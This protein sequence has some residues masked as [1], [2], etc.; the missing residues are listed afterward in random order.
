MIHSI[1]ADMEE[2]WK[3]IPGY[4][5]WYKVSNFGRVRSLDRYVNGKSSTK[6]IRKGRILK[7]CVHSCGYLYLT[8]SIEKKRKYLFIHRLV[9]EAFN[10]PIPEGM[11]VN[12]IN[13][14]K[15][16]NRLENLNLMTPKENINWGTHNKRVSE[17]HL[18]PVLQFTLDGELVRE[19]DSMEEAHKNGFEKANICNC[20]RGKLKQYKGFIWRYK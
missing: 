16:D 14:N 5:G 17:K 4:E 20:C 12:H 7:P 1:F 13:E 18:K 2:I 6:Q 11:Q 15:T 3:D 8:F 10:G 19:W 9:Y